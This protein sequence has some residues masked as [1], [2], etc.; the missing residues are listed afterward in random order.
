MTVI[1]GK[2]NQTLLGHVTDCLTAMNARIDRDEPVLRTV[3][4]ER[5][6]VD[7]EEVAACLRFAAVMHDIGKATD[8]WQKEEHERAQK[9]LDRSLI[10]HALPSAFIT[11]EALNIPRPNSD[12]PVVTPR[13]AMTL[14]IL[15]HHGQLHDGSATS[16]LKDLRSVALLDEGWS[17]LAKLATEASGFTLQPFPTGKPIPLSTMGKPWEAWKRD[18]LPRRND[19]LLRFKGL[20]CLM[21][22]LLRTFDVAASKVAGEIPIE[23]ASYERPGGP[24]LT[25]PKQ[26]P[27]LYDWRQVRDADVLGGKAPNQLQRRS[28]ELNGLCDLLNAGCGEGKTAL[29]LRHAQELMRASKINRV[30]FTLPTRFTSNN[31][32][33]DMRELYRL[34]KEVIGLCHGDSLAFLKKEAD[35]GERDSAR[36]QG[37]RDRFYD[38]PITLSTVDH[39]LLSL[40]HGYK[41]ADQ[42][43]GNILQSLVIF[44]ELHHYE[45]LTVSAIKEALAVLR[46]LRIPHLIMTATIPDTRTVILN[47]RLPGEPQVRYEPLV[48][49]GKEEPKDDLTKRRVKEAF[50]FRKAE[51]PMVRVL[52]EKGQAPRYIISPA[53]L[54]DL[55][56]HRH[57]RQIVFVNQVEKAKAVAKAATAHFADGAACPILCYHAEFIGQDRDRK[58]REIRAAFNSDAPCLLVATQIAELSLDI[59]AERMH[60]EIAPLDDIAQRGGRLNRNGV[61]PTRA[62]GQPYEMIVYP[63]DFDGPSDVLPYVNLKQHLASPL[64]ETPHLLQRSWDILPDGVPYRFDNVRNWVNTLYDQTEPLTHPHFRTAVHEDAVFGSRPQDRYSEKGED[65]QGQVVLR[66]REYETFDVVPQKFEGQLMDKAEDNRAFLLTINQFKFFR[67]KQRELIHEKPVSIRV[68]KRRGGKGEHETRCYLILDRRY[69]YGYEYGVDFTGETDFDPDELD[70]PPADRGN[71]CG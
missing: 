6:G 18:G 21:A 5:L 43:F 20:Y 32:H 12:A 22:S 62:D 19:E 52:R 17:E 2:E 42:A 39:L 4:A 66:A 16:A 13:H 1:L 68:F 48:S 65:D 55:H 40:Y 56:Q 64:A 10:T 14:A 67:A 57:L 53:L 51:E 31:M 9:H 45:T 7:W 70:S 37:G 30:I 26:T 27:F 41:N 47:E 28:D 58:E 59:S 36:E 29:A 3:C 15:G 50:T 69:D 35:E 60:S 49:D 25:E 23:Q 61:T 63:L 46:L 33:R 11:L 34:P 38:R 54:E 24:F 44:D 71:I 8:Q